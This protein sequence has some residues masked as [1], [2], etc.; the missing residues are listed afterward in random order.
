MAY[1]DLQFQKVERSDYLL[2]QNTKQYFLVYLP[3]TFLLF[4]LLNR[5]F[6]GLFSLRVSICLRAYS[7]WLQLWL[8]AVVQNLSGLWFF[9]LKELQVLFSLDWTLTLVRW[10]TVPLVGLVLICSICLFPLCRYFYRSQ[11]KY[12][13]LNLRHSHSS[14]TASWYMLLRF[15]LKPLI[16]TALHCFLVANTSQ[17]LFWLS[18][19]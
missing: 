1:A 3:L 4:C 19:S 13:L 2:V 9:C 8:I 7:F 12:F 17:I 6:H 14:Y 5:L 16:E 15:V 18:L 11:A 10:L